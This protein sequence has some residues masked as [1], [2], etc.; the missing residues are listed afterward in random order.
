[1][2]TRSVFADKDALLDACVVEAL[3]PTNVLGELR[4]ISLE[5][6]L[7]ARL[8]EAAEALRA[9]LDRMGT[10]IGA[11]HASGHA[12]GQRR[13]ADRAEHGADP[14]REPP[15]NGDGSQV[16]VREA[17]AELFEPDQES[18][19]LPV[20]K[21]TDVFLALTFGRGRMPGGD[22]QPLD[23]TVLVDLFLHG[24]LIAPT[25]A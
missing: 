20:E 5:Q 18:L 14:P 24:A 17:F 3:D 9:H 19:R 7:D 1:L 11:L 4:S 25:R 13:R 15:A 8:V 21:L 22:H 12:S 23:T 16:A 10:V 2:P 6:P